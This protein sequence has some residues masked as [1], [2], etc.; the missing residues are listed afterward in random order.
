[1][2]SER[3]TNNRN[4]QDTSP[5]YI[6]NRHRNPRQEQPEYIRDKTHRPA[7]ICNFLAKREECKPSEFK[8]LQANWNSYD[9]NTPAD[10]RKRP[11]TPGSTAAKYIPKIISKYALV[12]VF[13]PSIFILSSCGSLP[14]YIGLPR[15]I[16]T[17][18]QHHDLCHDHHRKSHR[19]IILLCLVM[20]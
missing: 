12:F 5:D 14:D 2:L 6:C 13:S 11:R 20:K 16:H 9:R 1:M 17:I 4:A 18:K 10:S 8:A 15:C 7:T 3:N 19:E